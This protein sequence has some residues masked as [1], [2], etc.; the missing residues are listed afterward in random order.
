MKKYDPALYLILAA[1]FAASVAGAFFIRS[2]GGGLSIEA[3]RDGKVIFSSPLGNT[4]GSRMPFGEPG[5]FNEIEFGEG[6]RMV[7]ADCPGGDCLRAG[8]ITRPGEAIV[9]VP[10]KLVIRLA[11]RAAPA[12]DAVSR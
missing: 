9:C 6:V 5:N 7:S 2:G 4:P 10:H 12:V 8:E 1:L 3:S 11:S